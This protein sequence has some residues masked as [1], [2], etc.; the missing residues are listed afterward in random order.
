MG[1]DRKR[2]KKIR[3]DGERWEKTGIDGGLIG[4]YGVSCVANTHVLLN[5]RFPYL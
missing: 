5:C 3:K 2:Y 1:I 4:E